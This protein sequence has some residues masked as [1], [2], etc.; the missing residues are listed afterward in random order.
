[1][2]NILRQNRNRRVIKIELLSA[3]ADD[4][5]LINPTLDHADQPGNAEYSGI[6]FTLG[7]LGFTQKPKPTTA[8]TV[9]TI[10][11]EFSLPNFPGSEKF[12]ENFKKVASVRL[13]LNTGGTVMLDRNDV[14]LNKPMDAEIGANLKTLQFSLSLTRIFP[15]I[16]N[17]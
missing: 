11:L 4:V 5:F 6:Y 15:F 1:M 13:S 9:Y 3:L 2:M 10:N 12:Q 14:S 16:I 7:S 17:E 8:G